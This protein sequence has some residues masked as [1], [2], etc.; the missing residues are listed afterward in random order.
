M[1]AYPAAVV[2][3]AFPAEVVPAVVAAVLPAGTASARDDDDDSDGCESAQAFEVNG[4]TGFPLSCLRILSILS[5]IVL[6]AR[7]ETTCA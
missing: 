6:N 3:A 2:A 7:C 5:F 4:L 1:P